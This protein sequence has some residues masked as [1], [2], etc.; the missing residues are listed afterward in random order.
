MGDPSP[1]I[2]FSDIPFGPIVWFGGFMTFSLNL[3]HLSQRFRAV[4]LLNAY[5]TLVWQV[6]YGISLICFAM[7]QAF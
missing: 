7:G 1:W 2:V 6:W 4:T 5:D 3:L